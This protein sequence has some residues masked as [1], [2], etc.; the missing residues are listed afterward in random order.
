MKRNYLFLLIGFLLAVTFSAQIFA[1]PVIVLDKYY[2]SNAHGYGDVIGSEAD[3]GISKA[4]IELTGTILTV[5]IYTN[6]AGKSG[7]LFNGDATYGKGIGYGD[8][9]LSSEWKPFGT[10]TEYLADN[11]STG[12]TWSYGVS[13]DNRWS[14]VGGYA[15]L[16]KLN[17][18]TTDTIRSDS[19][20]NSTYAIFRNG[21]EVAVNTS[22]DVTERIDDVNVLSDVEWRVLTGLIRFEIDLKDTDLLSGKGIAFHWGETCGNDVIEGFVANPVPEPATML[23]LGSGLI[24]LAGFGRKKLLKKG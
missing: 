9:F 19:F 21:Q 8:L 7:N 1:V 10:G 3:F 17:N 4:T 20:I 24:G 22:Q 15:G 12:T 2:G 5:D 11:F 6:F 14:N 18:N 23:L 13:L 16:Y